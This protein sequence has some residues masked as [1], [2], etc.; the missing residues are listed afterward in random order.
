MNISNKLPFDSKYLV[1]VMTVGLVIVLILQLAISLSLRGAPA[2]PVRSS[3]TPFPSPTSSPTRAENESTYSNGI[4][5]LT[6]KPGW[7]IQTGNAPPNL[8]FATFNFQRSDIG[9]ILVRMYNTLPAAFKPPTPAEFSDVTSSY[10]KTGTVRNGQSETVFMKPTALSLADRPVMMQE[11]TTLKMVERAYYIPIAKGANDYFIVIAGIN[12][13]APNKEALFAT[14]DELLQTMTSSA[15]HAFYDH[16]GAYTIALS[17]AHPMTFKDTTL[18]FPLEG[19]TM[20]Y[21]QTTARTVSEF[22]TRSNAC[23]N[24][25]DGREYTISGTT[26]LLFVNSKCSSMGDSELFVIANN[27]LYTFSIFNFN[28]TKESILSGITFEK[29]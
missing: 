2:V 16:T 14:V 22:L 19:I 21:Q 13:N 10:W 26:G 20:K 15:K 25:A 7:T 28:N 12:K 17:Y 18:K 5:R 3:P 9:S 1:P 11:Y 24:P 6:L 23:Q 27:R 8:G 29:D 4:V